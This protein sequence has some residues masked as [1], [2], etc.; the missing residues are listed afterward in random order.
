MDSFMRSLI[1]NTVT[2]QVVYLNQIMYASY[3]MMRYVTFDRQCVP[4]MLTTVV[5]SSLLPDHSTRKY[6]SRCRDLNSSAGHYR[7][8]IRTFFCHF[9]LSVTWRTSLDY[10][11]TLRL[12][13]SIKTIKSPFSVLFR[14]IIMLFE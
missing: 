2:G 9:I 5:D 1:L 8:S 6:V 4:V 13:Y 12:F 7:S 14:Y 11:C 10:S 3:R